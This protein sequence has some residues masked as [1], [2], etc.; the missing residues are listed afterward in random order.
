MGGLG[1]ATDGDVGLLDDLWMYTVDTGQWTWVRGASGSDA[2]EFPA[3]YGTRGIAA[4]YNTPGSRWLAVSWL[5]CAGNLW[6][7]GGNG[8]PV[9]L[10]DLWE[11]RLAP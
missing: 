11:Y 7:F 10:N 5:D 4:P 8:R 2:I 3:V 9:P 6:L 1:F